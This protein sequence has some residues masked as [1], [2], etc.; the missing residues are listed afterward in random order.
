MYITYVHSDT[1]IVL[2]TANT[3]RFTEVRA[4]LNMTADE[5]LA[6]IERNEEEVGVLSLCS[7]CM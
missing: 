5:L 1:V 6:A 4:G 2:W 7:G 3:E